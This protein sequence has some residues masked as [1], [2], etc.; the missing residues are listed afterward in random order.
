MTL[1]P[2]LITVTLPPKLAD[3]LRL[4]SACRP[5]EWL[6]A[7]HR[8]WH[9]GRSLGSRRRACPEQAASRAGREKTAPG[10]GRPPG[11]TGYFIAF[12]PGVN[13]Q[14]AR[15]SGGRADRRADATRDRERRFRVQGSPTGLGTWRQGSG[16]GVQFSLPIPFPPNLVP[17]LRLG[18]VAAGFGVQF[19]L[20]VSF[21]TPPRSQAPAWE[22]GR[23]GS[24]FGVQFSLPTSF[25]PVSRSQAP[26]WERGGRVQGSGFSFRCP[27]R[28]HPVS[29]PSSGLGTRRQARPKRHSGEQSMSESIFDRLKDLLDRHGIQYD[30]LRHEAVYTSQQAACVRGTPLASGATLICKGDDRVVMFV[31][32]ADRRLDSRGIRRQRNWRKAPLSEPRG[33]LRTDGLEPGDPP[34]GQLFGL[35]TFCDRRPRRER[36]D[37]LQRRRPLHLGRHGLRRLRSGRE[38]RA[39]RIC[40]IVP[41]AHPG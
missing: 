10:G 26:A 18:N 41:T 11:E 2:S 33:S 5:F 22:R 21:P 30:V 17:K 38:P 8:S 7:T 4:R 12:E 1:P 14:T 6:L 39:R 28:S 25:P 35:P 16:F 37:Q 29:F 27:S 36:A 15:Q 20:P 40:G 3:P 9:G 24:G 23:R 34:F 13:A 31:L 19:S 32:P